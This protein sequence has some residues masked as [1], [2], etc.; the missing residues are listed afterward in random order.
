[1]LGDRHVIPW[2]GVLALICGGLIIGLRFR[3][4]NHRSY[5]VPYRNPG[6]AAGYRNVVLV[7]PILAVAFVPMTILM[8][9]TSLDLDVRL[10]VS[11]RVGGFVLFGAIAALLGGVGASL[12]LM[13][14]PPRW[15]VPAWLREEDLRI[16]FVPPRP[17][18]SDWAMLM[19]G[20]VLV[21]AALGCLAFATFELLVGS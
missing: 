16:R 19:L 18:W 21:V 10:D 9:P 7:M 1:M 15:L 2:L 5:L 6:L 8:A 13:F 17:G 4:G 12:A 3:R 11:R 20:L 14:R